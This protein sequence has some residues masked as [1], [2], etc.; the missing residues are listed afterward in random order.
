MSVITLMEKLARDMENVD[1]G[2]I[3]KPHSGLLPSS[4]HSSQERPGSQFAAPG[5]DSCVTSG[6]AQCCCGQ[7]IPRR[8]RP[9]RL[10]CPRRHQGANR[11]PA[12]SW[13]ARRAGAALG[14]GPA[15]EDA[16]ARTAGPLLPVPPSGRLGG[17]GCPRPGQG[18][19]RCAPA[20]V[21]GPPARPLSTHRALPEGSRCSLPAAP[22]PSWQ[23]RFCS[24]RR[25]SFGAGD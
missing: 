2:E 22:P 18:S 16:P 17:S 25:P 5:T 6:G 1:P 10:A 19:S 7:L 9:R 14:R 21:A 8:W 23:P 20:Q 11:V 15:R 12:S 13:D 3:P 4:L 24:R